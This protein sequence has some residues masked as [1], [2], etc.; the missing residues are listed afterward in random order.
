MESE[1]SK[2]NKLE[3]NATESEKLKFKEKEIDLLSQKKSALQAI[4]KEQEKENQ[5]N[6]DKLK[7]QG[8][9]FDNLGNV[10]NRNELL[11]SKTNS[12][13]SKTGDAK[14][15]AQD[16]VKQFEE[17]LK[18]YE[19]L[20]FSKITDTSSK[21]FELE[22]DRISKLKELEVVKFN[23]SLQD[24]EDKY[25]KESQQIEDIKFKLEELNA[26]DDSSKESI[27][28]KVKLTE[29][30]IKATG[31]YNV[32]L[33]TGYGESLDLLKTQKEGTEEWDKATKNVENYKDKLKDTYLE[34]LNLNK[35][36]KDMTKTMLT[37]LIE[38]QKQIAEITLKQQQ[39]NEKNALSSK[40]VS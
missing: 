12:A 24:I 2:L 7:K 14:K 34:L 5:S 26:T 28:Q 37:N 21:I 22:Q 40:I 39:E 15:K 9:K 8:A 20:R 36:Q 29:D 19:D 13:N 32:Q 3:S 17:D 33:L 25:N 38:S 10:V 4:Y 31:D 18:S 30:L 27:Q 6:A 16:Y 23:K 35:S 1:L 11:T